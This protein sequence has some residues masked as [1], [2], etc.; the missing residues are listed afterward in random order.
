MEIM[1]EMRESCYLRFIL[2]LNAF[3]HRGTQ[4]AIS[5]NN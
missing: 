5:K 4:T 3:F 2:Q 1:S